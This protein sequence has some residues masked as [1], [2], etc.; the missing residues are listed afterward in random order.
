MRVN[1]H[2]VEESLQ[3]QELS[4]PPHAESRLRSTGYY[5]EIRFR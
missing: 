3:V 2:T 4:N 5:D 1:Y